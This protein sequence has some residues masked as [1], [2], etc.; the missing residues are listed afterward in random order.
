MSAHR[1]RS[2]RV[3][4]SSKVESKLNRIARHWP[5]DRVRDCQATT[6]YTRSPMPP[7]QV[8]SNRVSLTGPWRRG[9][10]SL[11]SPGSLSNHHKQVYGCTHSLTH[12]ST[13]NRQTSRVKFN[14]DGQLDLHTGPNKILSQPIIR[15]MTRHCRA[16]HQ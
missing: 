13:A 14:E 7:G 5:F 12:L 10:W 4:P 1:S 16:N 6:T 15:M 9:S 8:Q 11:I 2:R 3:A